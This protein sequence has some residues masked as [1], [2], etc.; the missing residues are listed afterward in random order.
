MTLTAPHCWILIAPLDAPELADRLWESPKRL[1]KWL[2][3][4]GAEQDNETE[5]ETPQSGNSP[6]PYS[7]KKDAFIK[8]PTLRLRDYFD[9]DAGEGHTKGHGSGKRTVEHGDIVRVLGTRC[10]LRSNVK[11]SASASY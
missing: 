6:K 10:K 1:V 7:W 3:R 8:G 11:K 5:D 9:E 4:I 2:P